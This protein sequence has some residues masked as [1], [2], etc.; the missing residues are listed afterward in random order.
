MTELAAFLAPSNIPPAH[1]EPPLVQRLVSELGATWVD[2][3]SLVDF[4]ARPGD[5]VLFFS[6]DP[7]RFPE[8]V[9]VAGGGDHLPGE[10]EFD[11]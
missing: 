1:V 2:P 3:D 10:V 9:D 6:G 7:V 11:E 4:L 8:G 5:Q